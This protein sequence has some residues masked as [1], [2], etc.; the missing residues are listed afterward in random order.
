MRAIL[1]W[2]SV[3]ASGSPISVTRDEFRRQVAWLASGVVRVVSLGEL[4][5]LPEDASAVALT[6]DDGFANFATEAAPLLLQHGLAVTLF[7][8]TR[9]L[10]GD[11]RWAGR[12][13]DGIPV[14]PLLDWDALGRLRESGVSLGAH[15]RTHPRLTGLGDPEL[16]AELGLAAEEMEQRLG[17]RPAAVAYPY[18]AVDQRIAGAASRWYR[19][20]CTT[21]L[22][23]LRAA[24]AP[25]RLPRL[26]AWYL[27]DP[28]R[29]A[30][31]GGQGFLAWLWCRRQAR[32][33]RG[34]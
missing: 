13:S 10:G 24:E 19:W 4:C 29:L 5:A 34:H 18:G 6:F 16:E 21:E 33:L 8:V 7:V 1:T 31:W 27:R 32:R 17:E 9:H 2:H 22:R 15:T 14:L 11:N 30:A 20:G 12:S 23:T 25:L 28:A 3:D 26:D